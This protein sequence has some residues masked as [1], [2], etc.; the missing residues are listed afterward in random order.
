MPVADDRILGYPVDLRLHI[1]FFFSIA[2]QRVRQKVGYK[3]P[4]LRTPLSASRMTADAHP[5]CEPS[6]VCHAQ[7][8]VER[9]PWLSH[10]DPN[11]LK[12]FSLSR[13][14]LMLAVWVTVGGEN[15]RSL[16]ISEGCTQV[17]PS[18]SFIKVNGGG[19]QIAKAS[20]E[21]VEV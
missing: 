6:T 9:G 16:P 13:L 20:R 7:A 4:V 17:C 19:H 1:T 14:L 3:K 21:S 10:L 11:V 8:L 18:K 2:R 5:I 12:H 15:E